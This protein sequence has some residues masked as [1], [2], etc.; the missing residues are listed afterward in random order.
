ML[1]RW[2]SV[3]LESEV[4]QQARLDANKAAQQH[5]ETP[6]ARQARITLAPN[7]LCMVLY[8]NIYL[9]V[10]VYKLVVVQLPSAYY[11]KLVLLILDVVA[12]LACV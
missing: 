7:M 9:I 2:Q 3:S 5:A 1:A 10:A 12:L 11:S 8:S 4:G 6:E